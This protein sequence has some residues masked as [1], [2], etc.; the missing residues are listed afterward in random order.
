MNSLDKAPGDTEGAADSQIVIAKEEA[1]DA[2]ADLGALYGASSSA[3][4][5]P[6]RDPSSSDPVL[7]SSEQAGQAVPISPASKREHSR[8]RRGRRKERVVDEATDR[9]RERYAPLDYSLSARCCL[10]CLTDAYQ[11]STALRLYRPGRLIKFDGHSSLLI[12][13]TFILEYYDNALSK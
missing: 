11:K 5:E 7:A 1:D 9:Q 3:I 4:A 8:R 12:S 13:L 10:L 6:N 2:N